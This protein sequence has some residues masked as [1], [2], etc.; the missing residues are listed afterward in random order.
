M[1]KLTKKQQTITIIISTLIFGFLLG[2]FTSGLYIRKEFREFVS[3]KKEKGFKNLMNNVLDL[4]EE[5]TVLLDSIFTKH[6]IVIEELHNEFREK[7]KQNMDSLETEMSPYLTEDQKQTLIEM[8]KKHRR[9]RKPFL[10]RKPKKDCNK[11]K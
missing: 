1:K 8:K 4:S 2:V 10:F 3:V 9:L 7:F 5:Q 11:S 6:A